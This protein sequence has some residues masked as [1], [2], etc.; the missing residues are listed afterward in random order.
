[1]A[2]D[3]DS[4]ADSLVMSDALATR[5]ATV[6]KIT[7]L[8]K[9]EQL[10]AEVAKV[11]EWYIAV[12]D[13]APR[14]LPD[15]AARQLER[16]FRSLKRGNRRN[17][18]ALVHHSARW[19]LRAASVEFEGTR[20][21]AERLIGKGDYKR[22]LPIVRVAIRRA[23]KA[24]SKK[25]IRSRQGADTAA[26]L[27]LAEAYSGATGKQPRRGGDDGPSQF[28]GFLEVALKDLTGNDGTALAK[29]WQRAWQIG[30]RL[31]PLRK[32]RAVMSGPNS[33]KSA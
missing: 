9:V 11:R 2:E 7:D 29:R 21:A 32:T 1:M 12:V 17:D 23:H 15:D 33:G 31:R 28:E 27:M 5:L 20:Y 19:L 4:A 3:E 13:A 18:R 6:L 16:L 24:K 14:L 30:N 25:L 8:E 10:R 26:V 22:V